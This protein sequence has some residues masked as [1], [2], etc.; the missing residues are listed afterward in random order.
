[1]NRSHPWFEGAVVYQIYPRSFYDSNGDGIGD[2]RGI[3]QK[4]DYLNSKPESLGINAIWISPFYKSPMADFG[5]DISDYRD[6]DPIF[7]SLDD[8]K[9]LVQEAHRRD[10]RVI[11]D[12]VPCHTSNEH[13]WFLESKSSKSS[14][15]RDWYVWKDGSSTHSAPNNWLSV[16]G[17]SAWEFDQ[18][19]NQ[20]YLHSFL[21]EQP[22]LNWDN[23]EVRA[24]I[25]NE[26]RFWL[27]LDIDGLRMDAVDRM[28]KDPKYRDDS[29]NPKYNQ[30]EDDPYIALVHSR[31][32]NGPN[33]AKY[34]RELAELVETYKDRF[35]VIEAYPTKR[36][37]IH[38]YI[39]LYRDINSS[40]CA[41]FNF[42]GIFL[43]W[44]ATEYKSFIDSFQNS[45]R[46]DDVPIYNF[47]NHDKSR[48]ATRVGQDKAR[49]IAMLQ[50]TLPGMPIMYYGDELGMEDVNIPKEFI[51][52]PVEKHIPGKN[53][54]RDPERTPMQWSG[55]KNSGFS[56][57]N[58]WLPVSDDFLTR[59]VIVQSLA[60]R[61]TLSLYRQLLTIRNGSDALK[62]GKY[63][64]VNIDSNVFG[65]IREHE[66]KE[67]MILANFLDQE[68]P[69]S[70][71]INSEN[72]ICS[73]YLD[74]KGSTSRM[75]KNEA[76][77]I[78]C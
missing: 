77:I 71:G 15:R 64:P 43:P 63:K 72:I 11:I 76:L 67:I 70:I 27:D 13:P 35:M 30:T 25:K 75:R 42:E 51:Q 53:L 2:L 19:T 62:Y 41:P 68:I 26:I 66:G 57:S 40:V 47:G 65:F 61:S 69:L 17:G 48:I 46:E 3:I 74:G 18:N 10:I 1:M 39:K 45:L 9:R 5:Y 54:G 20:Y 49:V 50:L 31:S 36:F 78:N 59:N 7:G 34:L 24:A 55:D 29:I 33:L 14:P 56:T 6:V 22:D 60:N 4:L 73:T 44:K 12:F 52:D 32:Y 8:F 28:S 16:F 38:P 37:D 23:P 58:P 21:A